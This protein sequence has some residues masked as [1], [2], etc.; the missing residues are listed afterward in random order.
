MTRAYDNIGVIY[1]C[2]VN[3]GKIPV[4]KLES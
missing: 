1:F 2:K 3:I 4:Q